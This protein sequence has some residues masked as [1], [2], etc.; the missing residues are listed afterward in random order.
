MGIWSSHLYGNDTT[1]DVRDSYQELIYETLD[2]EKAYTKLMKEYD[3]YLGTDE[4]PLVWYAIAD[5]Q[6]RYGRLMPEVK[7]KAIYW[8]DNNGGVDLWEEDPKGAVNFRKN[9]LKLKSKI[10]SPMPKPK[11]IIN[12]HNFVHNP[13]NVGDVYAFQFIKDE[14]A[15]YGLKHKYVLLQKIGNTKPEGSKKYPCSVIQV[16]N[17]VFDEIPVLKEIQGLKP[18]NMDV[19]ERF[20]FDD[21]RPPVLKLIMDMYK[22]SEYSPKRFIF[23]GNDIISG[24]TVFPWN[25]WEKYSW[26][27]LEDLVIECYIDWQNHTLKFV[28]GKYIVEKNK[29]SDV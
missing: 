16:F 19:H 25:D 6:W 29:Y 17:K 11:K 26:R 15:C 9:I 8:I 3:E 21:K 13:W 22:K 23:I 4:E 28:D 24:K 20:F 12:P 14:Y 18:L 10:L 5:L 27:Y 2:I 7:D 1:T